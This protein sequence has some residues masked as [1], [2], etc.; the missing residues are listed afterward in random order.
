MQIPPHKF[1]PGVLP[2]S[3][4]FFFAAPLTE[5]ECELFYYIPWYSRSG[6]TRGYNRIIHIP[7]R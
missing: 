3:E 4:N 7:A 2:E 5:R 6:R 1:D